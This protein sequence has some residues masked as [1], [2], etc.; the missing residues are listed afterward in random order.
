MWAP[1]TLNI[2]FRRLSGTVRGAAATC[3]A[4]PNQIALRLLEAKGV[5]GVVRRMRVR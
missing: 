3:I 1:D 2:S 4:P 5:G